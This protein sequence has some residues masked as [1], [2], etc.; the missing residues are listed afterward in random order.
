MHI[1]EIIIILAL[2]ILVSN[3]ISHYLPAVPLSLIQI[4]LGLLT[5]LSG[6][7]QINLSQDWFLLV[8]IAPLLYTDGRRFPK[9]ELWRMR[10]PILGN[11]IL[12]VF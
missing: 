11:A 2:L 4:V 12:L 7:F 9:R 1:I 3:V 6:Q 5:S 10:G 8:F